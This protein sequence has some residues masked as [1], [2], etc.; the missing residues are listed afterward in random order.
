MQFDVSYSCYGINS[1]GFDIY[2]SWGFIREVDKAQR[3]SLFQLPSEI[4]LL[5]DEDLYSVYFLQSGNQVYLFLNH[6]WFT[7]KSEGNRNCYDG[8]SMIIRCKNYI[9]NIFDLSYEFVSS[10]HLL[11]TGGVDLFGEQQKLIFHSVNSYDLSNYLKRTSRKVLELHSSKIQTNGLF[12]N[13]LDSLSNRNGNVAHI[14][15]TCSLGLFSRVSSSAIEKR[16]FS[17]EILTQKSTFLSQIEE[18]YHSVIDK[19]NQLLKKKGIEVSN[20]KRELFVNNKRVKELEI[21]INNKEQELSTKYNQV[22]MK[23]KELDYLEQRIKRVTRI[24][25]RKI[26]VGKYQLLIYAS[27]IVLITGI[28]TLAITLYIKNSGLSP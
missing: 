5:N 1:Q 4:I 7:G 2:N 28:I 12:H 6:H 15:I 21:E 27:L 9:P 16:D 23:R 3:F 10:E 11:N 24:L 19:Q 14:Y 8:F 13:V 25:R 22:V 17:D 20:I 26:I 18:G